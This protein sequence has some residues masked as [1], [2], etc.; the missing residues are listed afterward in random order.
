[1]DSPK[2][3]K[4]DWYR[5]S[6][7]KRSDAQNEDDVS[8]DET[9]RGH[10]T[11]ASAFAH[12]AL[13]HLSFFLYLY[14]CYRA[15]F[16]DSSCFCRAS[17][18]ICKILRIDGNIVAATLSLVASGMCAVGFL[19]AVGIAV[20][21]TVKWRR[22]SQVSLPCI[23]LELP[24]IASR[25]RPKCHRYV[26]R[27]TSAFVLFQL[28]AF[29]GKPSD[30]LLAAYANLN[31]SACLLTLSCIAV[32]I[33]PGQSLRG[34][35]EPSYLPSFVFSSPFLHAQWVFATMNL[36]ATAVSCRRDWIRHRNRSP[37]SLPL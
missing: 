9:G 37:P 1:M 22:A 26:R 33:W 23:I 35:D 20:L 4:D 28:C 19:C 7:V 5:D 31:R 2:E 30:A 27:S 11:C 16:T 24:S 29:W 18:A 17:P 32:G 13:Q 34:S 8:D 14:P 10:A 21:H 15:H 3:I 12:I 36:A 6:D 25:L